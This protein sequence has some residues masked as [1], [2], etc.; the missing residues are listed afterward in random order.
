MRHTL[1]V[2]LLLL[3]LDSVA[4][5]RDYSAL[6]VIRMRIAVKNLLSDCHTSCREDGTVAGGWC[7]MPQAADVERQ[8]LTYMQAG[9]SAGDLEGSVPPAPGFGYPP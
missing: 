7:N 2:G 1:I 4:I 5:A 9:V 6:D 8:L 3:A